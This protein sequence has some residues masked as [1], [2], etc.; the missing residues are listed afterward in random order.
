MIGGYIQVRGQACILHIRSKKSVVEVITLINGHMRTPKIE[1]LHRLIV[2]YNNKHGTL[3]PFLG[4]DETPLQMNSWLAG[5]LDSDAG[6]YFNWSL[7]NK[8]MPSI[9]QYYLR[10]SQRRFYHR[11]SFVGNSYA[12]IVRKIANFFSL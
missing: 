5:I 12:F 2:W 11:D 7:N 3:I 4:L 8:G 10:I 1:A 6:F 9:L